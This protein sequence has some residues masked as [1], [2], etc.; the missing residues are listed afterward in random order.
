[1]LETQCHDT[2]RAFPLGPLH[3][4]TSFSNFVW[5]H[6]QQPVVLPAFMP[7]LKVQSIIVL[8]AAGMRLNL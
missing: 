4:Y 1:M 3:G 7:C 6:F 8:R 2:A 5:V